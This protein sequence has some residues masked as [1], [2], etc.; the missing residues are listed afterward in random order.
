MTSD[1]KI[2]EGK[3]SLLF[4]NKKKQ[5]NFVNFGIGRA[6]TFGQKFFASF[7]QK[8]RFFFLPL[9]PLIFALPANADLSSPAR[10]GVFA[11]L[12]N[13]SGL[14]EEFKAGAS[15][16]PDDPAELKQ[17]IALSFVHPPYNAEWAAKA[18]AAARARANG[19]DKLCGNLGFPSLMIG[20][21]LMFEAIVTPEETALTFDFQETR[22]I[23]TD[24]QPLPPV[25]ERFGTTWGTS[26]GHWEGQT[27]VVDTVA[28][29][30]PVDPEGDPIS[31]Q[32]TYHER[33]RL[34]DK[35]TLQDQLT[36]TDPTALTH[37]WQL[38]R[39][40]TRVPN[41]TRFVEEEC[42][43][44]TRDQRVNGTFTISPP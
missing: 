4:V 25:D 10:V 36:I 17:Q 23:Y 21:A 35:N 37:P 7:F 29:S 18:A 39:T 26:V 9:L 30:A 34:I 33:I 12:P 2:G 13:W 32:A 1:V 20:S 31:E 11:K 40:Y 28:S 3:E 15:G 38:T 5:K 24:G 27:L 19:P 22:H 42:Y 43:G 8:R 14:W 16:G 44:N 41:M 6:A